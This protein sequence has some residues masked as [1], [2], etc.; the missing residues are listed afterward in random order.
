MATVVQLV[1]RLIRIHF[2]GWEDS[3]DQWVDVESPD[4][5]PTGWCELMNYNLERPKI[6]HIDDKNTKAK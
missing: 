1:G 6:K 2:D 3:F 5:Y 4:I